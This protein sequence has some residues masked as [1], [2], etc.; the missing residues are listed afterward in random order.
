MRFVVGL[1]CGGIMVVHP[2]TVINSNVLHKSAD[3]KVAFTDTFGPMKVQRVHNYTTSGNRANSST[4]PIPSSSGATYVRS[5]AKRSLNGIRSGAGHVFNG[6]KKRVSSVFGKPDSKEKCQLWGTKR[7]SSKEV[8]RAIEKKKD[9][10]DLKLSTHLTDRGD[11][12]IQANGLGVRDLLFG[13]VAF[14]ATKPAMEWVTT[15]SHVTSYLGSTVQLLPILVPAAFA[16]APIVSSHILAPRQKKLA[17]KSILEVKPE[18]SELNNLIIEI[19]NNPEAFGL[20]II[21]PEDDNE[22]K[23]L[24]ANFLNLNLDI[25]S[26]HT[27]SGDM[28]IPYCLPRESGQTLGYKKKIK[29][30]LGISDLL[31]RVENE[32]DAMSGD[33]DAPMELE[34]K[35]LDAFDLAKLNKPEKEP[36]VNRNNERWDKLTKEIQDVYDS[37]EMEKIPFFHLTQQ[38]KGG[39]AVHLKDAPPQVS[40]QE[41]KQLEKYLDNIKNKKHKFNLVQRYSDLQKKRLLRDKVNREI[42]ELRREIEEQYRDANEKPPHWSVSELLPSDKTSKETAQKLTKIL[43]DIKNGNHSWD[44]SPT[45]VHDEQDYVKRTGDDF[46]VAINA[47]V[48]NRRNPSPEERLALKETYKLFQKKEQKLLERI[49]DYQVQMKDKHLFL[50]Q[51]QTLNTKLEDIAIKLGLDI[52]GIEINKKTKATMSRFVVASRPDMNSNVADL[53]HSI[54]ST[55]SL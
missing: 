46:F 27:K 12:Q 23:R 38:P 44:L 49:V 29:S 54:T 43:D 40:D 13:I 21:N 5:A 53:V 3:N 2:S 28:T 55:M 17:E 45:E 51:L 37:K 42:S 47:F 4:R 31:T 9:E 14:N 34:P 50:E 16:V 39:G 10:I 19:K 48:R 36:F 30:M 24:R 41:I 1:K 25:L 33:G 11:A 18:I 32:M 26:D 20:R 35:A 6:A 15:L 8:I 52:E 7:V 22:G